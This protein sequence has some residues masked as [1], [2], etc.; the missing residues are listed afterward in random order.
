M[1]LEELHMQEQSRLLTPDE[2]MQLLGISYATL[3][4][5]VRNNDIPFIRI[6]KMLR[7]PRSFFDELEERAYDTIKG[8]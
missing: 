2:V 8:A 7:F 5:R 3:L 6:G 1:Q 4:R